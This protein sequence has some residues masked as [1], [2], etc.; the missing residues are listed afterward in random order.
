MKGRQRNSRFGRESAGPWPLT[1][2]RG[3]VSGQS[4]SSLMRY[5]D[6]PDLGT[7]E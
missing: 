4:D 1:V 7:P 5:F 3:L 2:K 6:G